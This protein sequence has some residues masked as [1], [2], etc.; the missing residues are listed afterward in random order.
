MITNFIT[1]TIQERLENGSIECFD[2]P[3]LVRI[4]AYFTSLDDNSGLTTLIEQVRR[5]STFSNREQAIVA[6]YI[7][8]EI[9]TILDECCFRVTEVKRQKNIAHREFILSKPVI[10]LLD[11]QKLSGKAISFMLGVPA[12][13]LYLREMNAAILRCMRGDKIHVSG[14]LRVEI[15]YWR[16]FDNW[17]GKVVW[18]ERHLNLEI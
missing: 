18:T 15:E 5:E 10:S 7:T 1:D 13:R 14:T 9:L 12:A 8:C 2:I 3:R 4:G 16:F 6:N 11:L 17:K